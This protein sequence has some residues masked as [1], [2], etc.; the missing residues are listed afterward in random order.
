MFRDFPTHKD[1]TFLT[2]H[3]KILCATVG[4]NIR[5]NDSN[6]REWKRERKTYRSGIVRMWTETAEDEER[7]CQ[8]N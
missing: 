5:R 1:A 2:L 8:V 3:T 4:G 7:V 6:R